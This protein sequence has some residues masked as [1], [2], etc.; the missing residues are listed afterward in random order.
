MVEVID[1]PGATGYIDT[2]YAAKGRAAVA[3]LDRFDV[4]F[5]H[6]EAPDEAGHLGDAAEKVKA[7]EQVDRHVVGPVLEK[8]QR[9]ESW[10]ILVAP[11]HPTPVEK[12]VHTANPPPILA[13]G[14][15]PWELGST[16]AKPPR[17]TEAYA[18]TT[19]LRYDPGHS[20]I[21]DFLRG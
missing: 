14:S 7:I 15:K 2:D 6:I 5:V 16:T 9:F 18:L 10:R 19:G 4:V 12:R 13:A 3:A 1:V 11:D 17:F 21:R 20:L 8:L